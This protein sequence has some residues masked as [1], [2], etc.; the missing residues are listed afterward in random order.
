MYYIRAT[1]ERDQ[2]GIDYIAPRI[3]YAGAGAIHDRRDTS[4][5][6]RDVHYAW[7]VSPFVLVACREDDV[8][9]YESRPMPD[10]DGITG[11]IRMMSEQP[12]RY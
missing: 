5:P 7:S 8:T 9:V 3:Q 11:E 10:T 1:I 4:D 12:V 2:S 6:Y